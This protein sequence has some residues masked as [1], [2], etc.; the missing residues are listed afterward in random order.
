MFY[1]IKEIKACDDLKLQAEFTNGVKK[2]YDVRNM[3]PVYEQMKA[4]ENQEL[5]QKAY[6]S[7]GGYAVIWSDQLDLDASD[8][9]ED[10]VIIE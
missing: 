5:F 1:K 10:G 6:V 7:P 4:L 8:I 9:W 2:E 3:F